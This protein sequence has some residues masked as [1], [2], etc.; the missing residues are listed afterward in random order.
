M[1]LF[2]SLTVLICQAQ[3]DKELTNIKW[4][5]GKEKVIYE[6]AIVRVEGKNGISGMTNLGYKS[7]EKIKLETIKNADS[8]MWTSEKK[9]KTLSMYEKFAFGGM[10]YLYLTR[11][12]IDAANT[13]MFSII[14]KDSTDSKE[15]LRKEFTSKIANVPNGDNYWWNYHSV[16]IPAK[17]KGQFFIYI[18]DKIGGDNNK[19]KFEVKQ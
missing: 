5:L 6:T 12:T 15:I 13:N 10:I 8:E 1:T 11:L 9:E 3:I 18:I 2:T 14:I 16:P 17:L 4:D 19:F 7:Y